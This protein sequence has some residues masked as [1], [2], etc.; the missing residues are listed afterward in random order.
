M[1][2]FIT[3]L[4]S[5]KPLSRAEA[6]EAML[7]MTGGETPAAQ[8]AALLTLYARRLPTCEELL[9]F[10]S[11]LLER[12]A[13][14]QLPTT[15]TKAVDLCGTGGDGKN[16]FNISTTA[17]FVVAA[18]GIPVIKH[19]NYGLSSAVGSSHLLEALGVP[20]SQNSGEVTA[21][22]ARS[23]VAFLHAPHWHPAMKHVAPIRKELGFRTIFN[24]LGPLVNPAQPR[25]GVVGVASRAVFDLYCSVIQE[26][27][28]NVIVVHSCDGYD[29]ISL[30][31]EALLFSNGRVT[32]CTPETFGATRVAPELLKG[33]E[34][35]EEAAHISRRLLSGEDTSEKRAVLIANSAIAYT[36]IHPEL[37]IA[38]A[39][40]CMQEAITSGKAHNTLSAS[41]QQPRS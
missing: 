5:D 8:I 11:A 13:P 19:G 39:Q 23:G 15:E 36:S 30:T 41:L 7:L 14:C 1:K 34:N 6:R 4:L 25:F 16:T 17:A 26:I 35:P 21:N 32:T 40:A 9:G 2:Q 27:E 24:L 12:A 28:S 22:L 29:E 18:A 10:R 20:F 38:E 33:G 37:S 31:G 3:T